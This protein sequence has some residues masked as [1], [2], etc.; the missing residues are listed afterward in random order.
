MKNRLTFLKL[1]RVYG[2]AYSGE[3]EVLQEDTEIVWRWMV[4]N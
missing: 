1:C 3:M 2:H 4:D